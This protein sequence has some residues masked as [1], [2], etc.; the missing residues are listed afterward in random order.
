MHRRPSRCS[1]A[2]ETTAMDGRMLARTLLVA[3]LAGLLVTAIAMLYRG[4]GGGKPNETPP[5]PFRLDALPAEWRRC[6]KLG[7]QDAAE[8]P[9]CQAFWE[10]NRRRFFGQPARPVTIRPDTSAPS[11]FDPNVPA[12]TSPTNT[13][14]PSLTGAPQR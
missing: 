4:G 6:S 10:E 9:R 8:D 14:A 7:P 3:T 13:P 11:A 12:S 2:T 1:A 5:P